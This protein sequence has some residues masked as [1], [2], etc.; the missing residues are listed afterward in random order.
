M[1]RVFL[2]LAGA[3]LVLCAGPGVL[4]QTPPPATKN[5][6]NNG[7]FESS[8]RRENLWHG[9]DAAGYL[10]GERGQVSVLTSGGSIGDTA[11]PISVSVA[12]MNGDGLLDIVTMDVLGYL[13]IFFN[14]G[15]K[16]SPKFTYGELG[17]IFLTRTAPKDP[18]IG[19]EYPKAR[20][21]PRIFAA[22]ISKSGK[23]DLVVGNYLGEVLLVPNSGSAQSPDFKQPQNISQL[24]VPTMKD[25]TKR[26]GNVFAPSLWDWNKDGK[27]DLLLGEG[28]YSANNIHLLINQGSGA[29]PV[30]DEN[31]RS[32]LAYGDGLEQL[33]PAVVD[34]NGDGTPDLLVAERSGKIAVYLNIG[35]TVK[36]GAPPPE[37]P[38][39]SFIAGA[40][41][42]P[43]TFG[44]ICTVSA[45][46]LNGDELFDL[47][48]GKTNGRIAMLLNV[49]TKSEPKFATPS[50]LK[51]QA[52]NP[53]LQVPSG[54]EIDYGVNRG[55]FFGFMDVVKRAANPAAQPTE[56]EACLKVGYLSSQNKIMPSPSVYT[57]AFPGF[58][59]KGPDANLTYAPARYFMLRQSE[60]FRFQQDT[61]Y[62]LTF[63]VKGRIS[64]GQA[65]VAWRGFKKLSDEKI[66]QG[67]RGSADVKKNEAEESVNESVRF[68]AGPTWNEV[69]K[70][71]RVSLKDKN[72]QD[73]K[74]MTSSS[75]EISFS[76]PPGGEVYFD[77]IKIVERLG[78]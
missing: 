40:A 74:L 57:P 30:F 33:T 73:L 15:T 10:G 3:W 19:R 60:R 62:I 32:I 53:P 11:M 64:D 37:I 24:L 78:M 67:E 44:G 9:V 45:G 47:V 38:F 51:G 4:A 35:A 29:R 6:V 71:F 58:E 1:M 5:L 49:G 75:L 21:A 14:S 63:K 61:S 27:D 41:G 66:V 39:T 77:D 54:W 18:T 23:K 36:P 22:D 31:N 55:N 13:R 17:G 59:I 20:L 76:I 25:P 2:A 50:E 7:S 52:R 16:E 8:A 69:R 43:M 26:W 56:G 72:L 12:D 68:S 34:Y 48:V 70:E 46:D 42:K 65:F 28:S